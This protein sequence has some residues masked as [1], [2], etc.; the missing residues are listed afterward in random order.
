[1]TRMHSVER[2]SHLNQAYNTLR[3]PDRLRSY[4][5]ELEG[6]QAPEKAQGQMPIELAEA[7]FE[8]QDVVME[9]PDEA[10]E[11]LQAF[12]SDLATFQAREE[13]KLLSHERTYDETRS[14][15]ELEAIARGIQAKSYLSS[16][17]R[18]VDRLKSRLTAMK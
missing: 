15:S 14:R 16:M 9:S 13:E 2:M 5:L 6:L 18:D 12:E 10:K 11:R 7:W 17:K 8:L 4:L 1:M 3:D